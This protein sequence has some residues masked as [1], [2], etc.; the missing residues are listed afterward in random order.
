MCN[1]VRRE[2]LTKIR[3]NMNSTFD[4]S[5]LK[6]LSVPQILLAFFLPSSFAFFGFRIIL[7]SVV[8]L[9]YP[10]VLMWGIVASV[11]LLFFAVIGFLLIKKETKAINISIGERL[12]IKKIG[13]KQWLICLGIMIVGILL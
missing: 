6:Q 3:M 11:M 7:P 9:G 1:L 2:N 8:D 12:L 4:W 5:K 10:K 13:I